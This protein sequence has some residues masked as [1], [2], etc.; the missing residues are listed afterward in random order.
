MIGKW[1]LGLEKSTGAPMRKGFDYSFGYLDQ[2][3]AHK[4]YTDHL[5]RNGERVELDGKQWSNDLFTQESLD[6][7]EKNKA[8]PFFL[9]L[10]YTNPHAELLVPEESLKPF[11]GKFPE[12]PFV[13]G[14]GDAP[15]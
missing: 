5:L 6:Y 1:G 14:Q 10:N 11:E 13:G 9:Y 8:A 7:F 15:G 2:V 4:Q 3:H 12:K